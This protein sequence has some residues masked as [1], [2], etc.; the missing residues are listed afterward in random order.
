MTMLSTMHNATDFVEIDRNVKVDG[1]HAQIQ[2]KQPKMIKDD[3]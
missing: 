2:V 3:Q 1:P